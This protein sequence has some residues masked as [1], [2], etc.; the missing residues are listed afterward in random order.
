MGLQADLHV[1]TRTTKGD[2]EGIHVFHELDV[3]P[4]IRRE[5]T[6]KKHVLRVAMKASFGMKKGI[7]LR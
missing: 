7:N 1:L 4:V 2:V 3:Q 6:Y 5:A